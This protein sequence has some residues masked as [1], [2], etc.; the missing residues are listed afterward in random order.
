MAYDG[1]EPAAWRLASGC[2]LTD[3]GDPFQRAFGLCLSQQAAGIG[4]LCRGV[5]LQD[6]VKSG[7]P[8][9]SLAGL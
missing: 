2:R 8:L 5:L 7:A 4:A 3:D 6:E 9:W 1:M